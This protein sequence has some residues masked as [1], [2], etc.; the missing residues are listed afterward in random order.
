MKSGGKIVT[1]KLKKMDIMDGLDRFMNIA[2]LDSTLEVWDESIAK[3]FNYFFEVTHMCN[4][5]RFGDYLIPTS[6]KNKM[7]SPMIDTSSSQSEEEMITKWLNQEDLS[8]EQQ[9]FLYFED[10]MTGVLLF[11][12]TYLWK[13][14]MEQPEYEIFIKRLGSLFKTYAKFYQLSKSESDFR[15]L[16]KITRKIN[17]TNESIRILDLVTNYFDEH[18]PF[19]KLQ[20]LLSHEQKDAAEKYRLFNYLTE[21]QVTIEAFLTGEISIEEDE[22]TQEI[23]INVPMNGKQGIYGILQFTTSSNYQFLETEQEHIKMI[24]H[25]AGNSLENASLYNQS[26]RLVA[27]LQL[28]N[29]VSRRLNDNLEFDEMVNFLQKQ[30]VAA[31]RPMEHAFVFIREGK[32]HVL[33]QSSGYFDTI[34]GTDLLYRMGQK[35]IETN[36]AIFEVGSEE[37]KYNTS[38]YQS[39]VATPIVNQS[40]IHGFILLVHK[41]K[42]AFSF[43]DFKLLHSIIGHASLAISNILLREQLQNLV[44][45][46]N[47]TKLYSRRFGDK[48]IEHSLQ[49]DEQGVLLILD[50]DDF[51]AVNDTFGHA[52]GDTVLLQVAKIVQK[53]VGNN[54]VASR[55]GGEEITI[56]LPGHALT[57]GIQYAK[58]ILKEIP[59]YTNPQVTVSMGVMYWTTPNEYTAKELFTYTDD[60]LYRAKSSGKNQYIIYEQ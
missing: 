35:I 1:E 48:A 14:F 25:S 33:N 24:A 32:L 2:V 37:D 43:D 34:E 3:I 28:V 54:G 13:E 41:D 42:Y 52:V 15:K 55:W 11:Q 31:F 29:E 60:A 45:R 40:Q 57:E 56:L 19:A 12:E 7:R 49:T 26:T 6:K 50:I 4:F 5:I 20:I 46:D 59:R 58:N 21:K 22:N 47:L 39:I 8:N 10:E 16:Y 53:I 36:E 23:I 9:L 30:V 44:D 27:D 17:S 18:F 51:K 38:L